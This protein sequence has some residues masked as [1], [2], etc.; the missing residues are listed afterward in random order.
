[1]YYN[2]AAKFHVESSAVLQS[3]ICQRLLHALNIIIY[4]YIYNY[5]YILHVCNNLGLEL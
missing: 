3:G 2:C 1:M 5:I 4:I